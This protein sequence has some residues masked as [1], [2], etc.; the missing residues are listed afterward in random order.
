MKLTTLLTV[1]AIVGFHS[2]GAWSADYKVQ[3]TLQLT[4]PSTEVWNLIGDFCDID[5]WHPSLTAC[6]LSVRDGGLHR[7]LTTADGD[8]FVEK[9]IANEPGLAYTYSIVSSPLPIENYTATFS[10]EP[11]NGSLISWSGR[12]SSEDPAMETT[13]SEIYDAGLSAIEAALA[14]Q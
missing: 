3:R 9:R 12:F 10:I 4:A 8:E 13:I 6:S 11:L 7:T 5:D 1:T 2:T 14:V